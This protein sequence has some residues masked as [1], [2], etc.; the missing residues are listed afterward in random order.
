MTAV[1]RAEVRLLREALDRADCLTSAQSR[2]LTA[3]EIALAEC[4]MHRDSLQQLAA[5]QQKRLQEL[6]T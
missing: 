6:E 3:L 4:R 2:T 5:G 1:D